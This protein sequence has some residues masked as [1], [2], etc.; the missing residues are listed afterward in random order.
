MKVEYVS[1]VCVISYLK[2]FVSGMG[3]VGGGRV[4]YTPSGDSFL[5]VQSP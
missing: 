1:N 2:F 5:W 3:T 4:N